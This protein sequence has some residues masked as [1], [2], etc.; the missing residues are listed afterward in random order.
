MIKFF[1]VWKSESKEIKDLLC[2]FSIIINIEIV[3]I[4]TIVDIIKVV[5]YNEMLIIINDPLSLLT[6]IWYFAKNN[7]TIDIII[8]IVKQSLQRICDPFL[9]IIN[10]TNNEMIL[11]NDV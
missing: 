10:F 5:F 1:N 3:N 11:F 9:F 4:T 6:L 2:S 7:L 8:T